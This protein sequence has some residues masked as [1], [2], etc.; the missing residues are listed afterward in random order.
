MTVDSFSQATV[1]LLAG[2]VRQQFIAKHADAEY[3]RIKIYDFN[4]SGMDGGRQQENNKLSCIARK[5]P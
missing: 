2:Q 5:E 4:N 3:I 1:K